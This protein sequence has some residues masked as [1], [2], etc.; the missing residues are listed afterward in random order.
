[1]VQNFESSQKEVS[2]RGL[3]GT[4]RCLLQSQSHDDK[5]AH[6]W[7]RFDTELGDRILDK[8]RKLRGTP[9]LHLPW[10]Y[11]LDGPMHWYDQPS[12]SELEAAM[13]VN[14]VSHWYWRLD[15]W[16][17]GSCL[18]KSWR[19]SRTAES[20]FRFSWVEQEYWYS[21]MSCRWL[22]M[23]SSGEPVETAANT[24]LQSGST[25]MPALYRRGTSSPRRDFPGWCWTSTIVWSG[26]QGT[27]NQAGLRSWLFLV[28]QCHF[29]GHKR[30]QW[31]YWIL[32]Q[33]SLSQ[34]GYLSIGRLV[35]WSMGFATC[36]QNFQ[37]TFRWSPSRYRTSSSIASQ[38]ALD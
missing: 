32:W 37:V 3:A 1:M 38:M 14:G 28:L 9:R 4:W 36:Q 25:P 6:S 8:Q 19:L 2:C 26:C 5:T 20:L 7:G 23:C 16:N 22:Y 31:C 15:W 10:M 13:V 35:L 17:H 18:G 29:G 12:Q 34:V 30:Y 27:T 24:G 21:S 11:I 33:P